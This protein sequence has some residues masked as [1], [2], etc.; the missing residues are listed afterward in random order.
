MKKVITIVSFY[1]SCCSLFAQ[2]DDFSWFSRH[3]RTDLT[4]ISNAQDQKIQGSCMIFASVAAVEAMSQIYYNEYSPTLHLSESNL[5]NDDCGIGCNDGEGLSV[6][7]SLNFIEYYGIVDESTFPFPTS[8]PYCVSNCGNIYTNNSYLVS[9]PHWSEL[10]DIDDNAELQK[11]IM[12]YGPII[13]LSADSEIGTVLHAGDNE[14]NHTVLVIGWETNSGLKWHIKDSWP[15]D[16]SIAYKSVDF[17]DFDPI[18]YRV[19]PKYGASEIDCDIFIRGSVDEDGDGFYNW[20]LD[21]EPKPDNCTGPDLMDFNDRDSTTICREGYNDGIVAPTLTGGSTYLCVSG[22]DFILND[23]PAIFSDSVT[24]AVTPGNCVSPSSG[25]GNTATITPTS[26]MGKRGTITFTMRY[27]GAVTYTEQFITNGPLE[28]QISVTVQSSYGGSPSK[29]GDMYYLCPNTIYYVYCNNS[30]YNCITS[31]FNWDLP[32]GW[33]EYWRT[34]NFISINT[35]NYPTGQL[36]IYAKTSCCSPQT[37]VKVFTQYFDRAGCGDF[38]MAFPNP[39]KQYVDIDIIDEKVTAEEI[40]ANAECTL[41]LFDKSGIVKY[42]TKFKGFPHRMN[43]SNL[44]E[45][46]YFINL[47]YMEKSSAL[48]IVIAR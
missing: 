16:P 40:N 47:N 48:R 46:I 13:M 20:G 17:F 23:V 6:Q 36:D 44:T 30:D 15:G 27:K 32:Y 19:W 1:F 22:D 9:I 10:V 5:Y 12:D 31:D 35:N 29:Y 4:Y 45:G 14:Y 39:S 3:G 7:A 2:P 18:F 8:T 34:S 25:S 41:T 21:T 33:T 28:S 43:T 11:A 26:F 24:W 42:N 37:R 38:F